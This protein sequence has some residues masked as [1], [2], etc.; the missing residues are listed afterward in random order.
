EYRADVI[1]LSEYVRIYY[2]RTWE[3]IKSNWDDV[4]AEAEIR[5]Q[6]KAKVKEFGTTS[7]K[8]Q[9]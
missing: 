7:I 5:Y 8:V 1:G 4:F 2:P 6:I 3:K 9:E